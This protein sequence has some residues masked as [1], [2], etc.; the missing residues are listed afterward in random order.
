MGMTAKRATRYGVAVAAAALVVAGC[1]DEPGGDERAQTTAATAAQAGD[2][3]RYCALVAELGR[4]AEKHF[5]GLGEGASTTEFRE[6]HVK[7]IEDNQE[8]ISELPRVAPPQIRAEVRTV[9][10]G[11]RQQAG[12]KVDVT[13]Q[14]IEAAD[15]KVRAFEQQRCQR[16]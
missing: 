2:V 1:G 7:L 11:M 6:A 3:E 12:E 13:A 9:L 16:S 4:N 15:R 10:A 5:S 14:D 8:T